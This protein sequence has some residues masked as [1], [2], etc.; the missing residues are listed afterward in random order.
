MKM[1]LC[2]SFLIALTVAASMIATAQQPATPA[3]KV[4]P[5]LIPQG[6]ASNPAPAGNTQMK[7]QKNTVGKGKLTITTA[8]PVD[9]WQEQVGFSNG[10]TVTTDFLYD[11]NVGVVYGYREDDFKC[12]N[13]KP[14][15]G[16]ILEALYTNENQ[17][18][19]PAGSGWYAVE[20]DE[21]K[22]AAKQAGIYGCKFDANGNA[23]EC[24]VAT[25]DGRTGDIAI[26][27]E[28]Q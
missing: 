6:K 21:N 20:L 10:S 28:Q 4:K 23:T 16:G 26:V 14:G 1:S 22:C 5:N 19:R 3:P 8:Q 12:A 17:M 27:A 9:F 24:G 2:R 11:S 15:F 25:I 13:G 18:K 7:T